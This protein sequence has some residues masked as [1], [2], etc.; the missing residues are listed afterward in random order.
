FL[1]DGATPH[2]ITGLQVRVPSTP[3]GDFVYLFHTD[4]NDVQSTATCTVL[5]NAKGN[6]LAK[7]GQDALLT[8][9]TFGS[10]RVVNF[11][12]YDYLRA[13]RFGFVMGLDDL[14]WRSLVWAAKKPFVLRGYPRF[15][16]PQQ[17][18]P[19][20]GW[21]DRIPDLSNPTF[22]GNVQADGTGGPWKVTGMIQTDDL[23]PGSAERQAIIS[24]ISAGRLK[25]APHTVTGGSDGDLYWTG[26]NPSPL[27]D[28][29]WLA[30]FNTLKGFQQGNGGSDV[31]PFSSSMVPH[32]WD[33]ADN[34]GADL[35]NLGIRYI[36][37]IQKPNVYFSQPTAKTASQ[38][39][40]SHPFRVYELP[41]TYGNPSE[42]WP[43]Y[44]ADDY[45]VNSRAGLPPKTF[46]S[47]A[48]Q[49]LGFTYP[50]FDAV[51]PN[52]PAGF[53]VNLALENWEVYTW[54]FWS[55]M[56]PVQVYNHDGGSME[57]STDAERQQFISTLSTWLGGRG[58]RHVYMEDLGAY[59]HARVKSNLVSGQVTPSTI[60]LNFSGNATDIDGKLIDTQTLV[61]YGDND[62]TPVDVP[63]FVNGTTISFANVTPPGLA[64]DKSSLTYGALPGGTNPPSQT[65]SVSNSGTGNLNW[66][67]AENASW[68]TVTPTSG[69]NS[70]VVTASVNI[71]GLAEGTYTTPITFTALG[72]TNSP[73]TIQVTLV[74]SSPKLGLTPAAMTFSGFQGQP[75]PSP[76]PLKIADVGG[77]SINWTAAVSSN[78]PWLTISGASG[79]APSTINV[80]ASVAGLPLGTYSGSVIVTGPGATNSPLSVPVTL[81]VSGILMASNFSDGTMQGWANSPLGRAT[82]WSVSNSTLQYNGG[83]HTQLYAGDS[84]WTDYS[85][86]SNVKLATLADYPGG[87]RGRID[88]VTGA[89]Y[90]L[91]LYPNE[92]LLKLFRTVAWNI[93]S[94]FTLLAQAPCSLDTVN[95][96][97]VKLA[98]Q[99]SA[100]QAS[101]DGNVLISVTDT[102]LTGGMV[103]VDVSNQVVSYTNAIVSGSV[104]SA[105]TI[106]A[107]PTSLSY[108][109]QANGSN[110]A[111]Q[112]FQVASSANTLAW[113][114]T[115]SAP[116]LTMSPS[117]G[118]TGT[119]VSVSAN[120][121]GL[122]SGTYNTTI[123]I[124]S[125]GAQNSPISIPV[126][127][128]VAPQPVILVASPI[129]LN[130]FGATTLNPL[131]RTIAITN[132]GAGA[133]NW[134]A[135]TD[136]S[137]LSVTPSSGSAPGT[138]TVTA[139]S[140]GLASGQYTGNVI[141]TSP[142][143]LN[144]P[145]TVPVSLHVGALLFSDDFSEGNSN[146]WLISPLGNAQNFSVVNQSF[147][148]N[149]GGATQA[150]TGSQSWT[151]Y[152]FSTDVTLANLNNFPGGIRARLNLTTGAGY[153]V[154]FYPANGLIKLYSVGQWN[155]DV[156]TLNLIAQA[157]MTFDTNV[158]NVRVDV[159]GTTIT[160]FYDG[161]QVIQ[162]TDTTY[163]SGGIALDVSTQPVQYDNVK[164]ISF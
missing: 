52:D 30:N 8:V 24:L 50:S 26:E 158:H 151:D 44:Y 75:D 137:W 46:F 159:Q 146:N 69:T 76:I 7:I 123:Q 78:T 11:G 3:A 74:I 23:D 108:I 72:A 49:L 128:T 59:L 117:S 163:T 120:V 109:A 118:N 132:G 127:F 40:N 164:V 156:G 60:T 133:M 141:L 148:Y 85:Y 15:F 88:P 102:T 112:T 65:I 51:W 104:A 56:A 115:S 41:P 161:T 140:I 155:I 86:Q 29:Q 143:A 95:F 122:A 144:S 138:V 64:V 150:Y 160:V 139:T 73:Q 2:Y 130:F 5:L 71:A 12:T 25:V 27:T 38:R 42:R 105:D 22:T 152:S 9:N 149:G 157:P 93:D 87:I 129:S 20:E 154:W 114:A 110:P 81:T 106:S 37:E 6:V 36:T 113:T 39:L 92:H 147:D 79:T 68:L 47:F 43:I 66:T 82:N 34:T 131:S 10:G 119:T 17:D 145:L 99:G 55:S 83:G 94:G 142:Q 96:H 28:A 31:L 84:S 57:H 45:T 63:G 62:G 111:V 16:A 135:T 58:V 54:R 13:D 98:F 116:W 48:T 124:V 91:W 101:V 153:A 14:F 103:G 125:K 33:I 1:P 70:G 77:G 18:D 121:A 35:W 19:V 136:S 162:A 126:T 21:E 67:V 80:A 97:T 89:S 4:D 61:F 32:F 100:I 134:T 107:S 53:S 90:A